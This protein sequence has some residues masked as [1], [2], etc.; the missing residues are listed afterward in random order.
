MVREARSA[1]YPKRA[2]FRLRW[3]VG[4]HRPYQRSDRMQQGRD[5][6]HGLVIQGWAAAFLSLLIVG[7]LVVD[8]DSAGATTLASPSRSTTIALTSDEE[9]LVVVNREANSLSIIQVK[10][11]EGNDVDIK[12][13]EIGVGVEPR[14]VAVHPNDEVAY[15]TNGI[16]ATVSVVDLV[17]GKVVKEVPSGTEPRGCAL[18]PNGNLLYVANHTEGTVSIFFTGSNPRNPIPVGAVPVGRNPTAVAITNNGDDN[19]A[20]ETVFVT[21]IFAELNPDFDDPVFNGNG[22]GRDLGKRGVVQAFPAGNA[23]PPITKITLSPLADSGFTANRAA[24]CPKAAPPQPHSLIFCPDPDLPGTDPVNANNPQGVFPNQLLSALIR[25]HRLYLPNIGAQPEPPEVFNVNVQALVYAVDTEALAEVKAEHVNLNQ[26]IAVETAAPPPSLDRTFGN[27]LVAI[28]ANLAG[29]TFL[30][31][32]RGGNQVFRASLGADGKLDILNAAKTRVD[33]RVQTGNLP[34][35]VA[36]R[37]D[38]TRAYANNEANFSVT[39]MNVDDGFCLTLQLDIASS[40]PPAPG[41]IQ[42]AQLLGKVAFFTA[43]GIPDNNI[44]GTDIRD[45]VPRN[46]K[47]KQSKD[48]WSSCGSCHPDG[49]A[50]GVT[51]IFGT[52]PRQTKSLDGM[53]N[54][55]TPDDKALLNWSAIRGSNTDFNNNSRATQ[56]GCGFA[57]DAFDPGACFDKGAAT[58]ANPAIYDHGITQG[59]SEAL[60]VQTLWIFFAVRP[61]NQPQPSNVGAGAAVFEANCASCHGGAKWTKSQVFHRDNPAAVAQNG[62]PLDPGV[63]RL[64]PAP[65]VAAV[66]ANEFFSFTCNELTVKYLE[67]VGTFDVSN[68]LEIR[69]N[70]AAS[71][72]FGV[73]GFNVPTLLS[74]NYSAP[75][76]HRGQAQTLEEVF[77]LHAL[78]TGTIASTLTAVEQADLLVFLKSIDGT[79]AHFR[80]EGDDFRDALRLQGPCPNPLSPPASSA[81]R[82]PNSILNRLGLR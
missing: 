79:T 33:C 66:P 60:D 72:A 22:E 48:A 12:L 42:H 17:L 70:A 3:M 56:G 15:V 18:T 46:F 62:A 4:F 65:P 82:S 64:A 40:T 50:D 63:T 21:Q 35:G 74:I 81:G 73:N 41:T 68:P 58:I 34:S 78:G 49:L 37:Q 54:K 69:D 1:S 6:Q 10:D 16:S 19:D 25:G 61:L 5:R 36:M 27:D 53:F 67:D 45:I 51:W 31:V 43:L 77:P 24:F 7:G 39:S 38:G 8:L 11:A 55:S 30:I 2:S 59:A 23:N 71:T 52:G 75:Y 14:C 80:S 28:D 44:L 76:L 32:S 47:G 20:D 26:Q 13:D 29:D 57:S 9:R